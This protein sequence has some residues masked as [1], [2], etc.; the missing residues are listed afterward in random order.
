M[1]EQ[2]PRGLTVNPRLVI[3]DDELEW[4]FSGSG[5]PGGQH[6]NTS[7]TKVDLRFDVATSSVLSPVQRQ[8]LLA[9][10]GPQ[11]KV[12]EAGQRSQARNR[13]EAARRL[14]QKVREGL[15]EPRARRPTR[16]GKGAVERRLSAKRQT[17]ERKSARRRPGWDRSD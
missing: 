2:P 14:A 4:R 7:N 12:V 17:A 5:G 10:Y 16:P 3:P 6:A 11:I 8:R 13:E 15:V 9:Q 1:P